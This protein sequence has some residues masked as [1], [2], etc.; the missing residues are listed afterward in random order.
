MQVRKASHC[1]RLAKFILI[2]LICFE[3]TLAVKE[4]MEFKDKYPES[5][6]LCELLPIQIA[7]KKDRKMDA[8][9]EEN[10]F[11]VNCIK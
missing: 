8:S 1:E 3:I 7:W 11:K 6:Y 4:I 10:E 2:D 9:G 5:S